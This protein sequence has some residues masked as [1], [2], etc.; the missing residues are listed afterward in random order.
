MLR[1]VPSVRAPLPS[2]SLQRCG[3]AIREHRKNCIVWRGCGA[4]NGAAMERGFPLKLTPA[5]AARDRIRGSE[6]AG[7]NAGG[8]EREKKMGEEER[9]DGGSGA[10]N[11]SWNRMQICSLFRSRCQLRLTMRD[12]RSRARERG[13]ALRISS[14]ERG[15]GGVQLSDGRGFEKPAQC[16]GILISLF[17]GRV[18][19]NFAPP[20]FFFLSL[21]LSFTRP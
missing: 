18:G 1:Y 10:R 7:K 15:V 4:R 6:S 11:R 5:R 20:I 9:G 16:P 21:S 12:E 17:R 19:F 8:G 3:P 2:L 13:S 14:A